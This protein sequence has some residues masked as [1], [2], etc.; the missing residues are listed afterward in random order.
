MGV[1]WSGWITLNG[2][3]T[4]V[5]SCEK[6]LFI[7]RV[8]IRCLASTLA[9]DDGLLELISEPN[10]LWREI[11]CYF[12]PCLRSWLNFQFGLQRSW[13]KFNLFHFTLTRTWP[14]IWIESNNEL[15][16][17]DTCVQLSDGLRWRMK[18]RC[19]SSALHYHHQCDSGPK[20]KGSIRQ[21]QSLC[22]SLADSIVVDWRLILT[23]EEAPTWIPIPM[24]RYLLIGFNIYK[25]YTKI[26][27]G[28]S[29]NNRMVSS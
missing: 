15:H 3:G 10:A 26:N 29:I 24:I 20:K 22:C 27:I 21:T 23:S 2:M 13:V 19:G 8:L 1:E 14:P 9:N 11:K 12:I 5:L 6:D 28:I 18:T 7:V 4:S 16:N 25:N 17:G